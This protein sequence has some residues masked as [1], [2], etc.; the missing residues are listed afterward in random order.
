MDEIIE[1]LKRDLKDQKEHSQNL[2]H[3]N[4]Q[5]EQQVTYYKN[6]LETILAIA[7]THAKKMGALIEGYRDT[8]V[9]RIK[10][11]NSVKK[12]ESCDELISFVRQQCPLI[13]QSSPVE[14]DT[15]PS[16]RR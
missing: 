16:T 15:R 3:R 5:L 4:T 7:S 2:L 13:V 8:I 11:V 10:E 1:K 14:L 9:K 12:C 6:H